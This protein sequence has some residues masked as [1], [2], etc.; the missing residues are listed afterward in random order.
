MAFPIIIPILLLVGGGI[1][2]AVSKGGTKLGGKNMPGVTY[3]PNCSFVQVT[4]PVMWAN[5]TMSTMVAYAEGLEPNDPALEAVSELMQIGI[6]GTKCSWATDGSFDTEIR[7]TAGPSQRWSTVISIL[8]GKTM[9]EAMDDG[10]FDAVQP[11]TQGGMQG[12]PL[13]PS[14]LLG[15]SF[16]IAM[17]NAAIRTLYAPGVVAPY[18][19]PAPLVFK[20]NELEFYSYKSPSRKDTVYIPIA[21]HKSSGTW[22]WGIYA[23]P[24]VKVKLVEANAAQTPWDSTIYGGDFGDTS[25]LSALQSAMAMVDWG[26]PNNL[27]FEEKLHMG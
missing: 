1:A 9:Q 10:S 11:G 7:P 5:A 19:P 15:N 6:G 17:L 26:G 14:R 16:K 3:G 13:Q 18:N 25:I 23:D 4:D 21:F 22:V 12:A 24:S 20:K 2:L 27:F 8:K